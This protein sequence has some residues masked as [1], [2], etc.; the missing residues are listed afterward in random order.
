MKTKA[1]FLFVAAAAILVSCTNEE[2]PVEKAA[3]RSKLSI[4]I[5]G[6]VDAPKGRAAG[7]PSQ[8]EE[9]TVNDFILFVF[10]A[11]G[12]NDI[13]PKEFTALPSGGKVSDI[14][15]T[16][17]AKEVYVVANTL[18]TPAVNDLLKTVTKKSELQAV[19][20]RGFTAVAATSPVTQT[21]TNLWMSG[22]NDADFTPIKDGNVSVAVTL[23][24]V[25]AKLRITK[26]TVDPGVTGLTLTNVTVYN[27]AAATHLIP[28]DGGTSLIPDYT[29]TAAAP[30]YVGG[31]SMTGLANKPLIA[32]KNNAYTFDLTGDLSISTTSN[33]HYFYV[34]ENDGETIEKQPTILS[35]SGIDGDSNTVNYSVF[36]KA[37]PDDK[38]GF[39]DQIIQRGRSYDVSMTIK[40]LGPEDPT[41][42][43]LKTTVEVTITPATWQ[44]I[45][46]D[47]VYE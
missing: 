41:I 33:Q 42:P 29:P 31:L 47:K 4:S 18:S 32:G 11:D 3:G 6:E 12:N 25:A 8:T 1:M 13:A 46:I 10:K 22:K 35:L 9:S 37:D 24:Y 36:F 26:V 19:T 30:F 20:G 5:K 2:N 23:T 44:T 7:A 28:A 17:D 39:D 43:A 27:G 40:K 21:S 34:F 15:I 38:L 16:T 45:D 14:E